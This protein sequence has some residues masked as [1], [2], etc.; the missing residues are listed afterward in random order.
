[1][2]TA[3]SFA[4]ALRLNRQE[5]DKFLKTAGYA[6]SNSS[7]RDVCIMFCLEKGIYEIDEVNALFFAIG[8]DPLTRDTP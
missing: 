8:I 2:N 1:M 6:L 4:L 3:I 5:L 7:S